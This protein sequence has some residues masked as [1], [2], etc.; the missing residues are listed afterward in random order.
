MRT[1]ADARGRTER[2]NLSRI[3]PLSPKVT[4]CHQLEKTRSL[5]FDSRRLHH[6][7]P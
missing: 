5:E 1:G 3:K 6:M 4:R 7:R 2:H